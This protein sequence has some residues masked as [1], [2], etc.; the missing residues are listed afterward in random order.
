VYRSLFFEQMQ[1]AEIERMRQ[2]EANQTALAA[3]G[4]RKKRK[5]DF[6]EVGQVRIVDIYS[7]I[8]A[9]EN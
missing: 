1:Q 6:G 8:L 4:P 9:T 7:I 2:E 3:I 5:T